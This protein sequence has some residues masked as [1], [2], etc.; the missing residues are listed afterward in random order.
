LRP[1]IGL[2]PDPRF[3]PRPRH[4]RLVYLPATWSAA[5][6]LGRP[7]AVRARLP[8]SR[9]HRVHPRSSAAAAVVSARGPSCR[10]IPKSGRT[11]PLPA[12]MGVGGQGPAL[13]PA[14]AHPRTPPHHPLAAT[15]RP[16]SR[17]LLRLLPCLS[18]AG[19]LFSGR[20]RHDRPGA[21]DTGDSRQLVAPPRRPVRAPRRPWRPTRALARARQ[22]CCSRRR[23]RRPPCP[24]GRRYAPPRG[25]ARRLSTPM[26]AIVTQSGT[27]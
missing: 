3:A 14:L 21:P 7:G 12:C 25:L 24:A 20:K 18:R 10:M 1:L 13:Q 6:L 16:C 9:R 15:R 27:P 19:A 5:R 11:V 22:S 23:R 2:L 4:L 17:T 26:P 8:L